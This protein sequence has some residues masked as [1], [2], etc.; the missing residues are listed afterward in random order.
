VPQSAASPLPGKNLFPRGLVVLMG[1]AAIALIVAGI[2][3]AAGLVGPTFLALVIVITIHPLQGWLGRRGVPGWLGSVAALLCAYAVLLVFASA[4]AYSAARLAGLVP[5]Y[6][7]QFSDLLHQSAA[8]LNRVGITQNQINSVLTSFDLNSMIGPL[9]QVLTGALGVVTDLAFIVALLFFLTLDAGSF[10]RRLASAGADRPHLSAALTSFAHGIRQYVV[11]SSIFGLV[12]AVGDVAALYWLSVPLPLL[13]GLLSF[14]TNYIPNI[15]FV[16][17]LAPPALLA[18]LDGGFSRAALV[19]LAY[20]VINVVIQSFIQP[21][22]VG[23]A[24]GLSVT[25]TF[26]SVV[27]WSY[28][29]GSLGALL[30]VPLSLFAK[31]LLVDA[32]PG[33]GWLVP[34]ITTGSQRTQEAKVVEG[35]DPT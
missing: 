26:L 18:L 10:P 25:L 33:S 21:K 27:F 22:F 7:S 4:L 19:V 34:L 8:W 32:D 13:W 12:C 23:E 14:L 1:G 9:Q 11:V 17:G 20:A 5:T 31:A 24:V 29:I 16:I 3:D 6:Q 28:A 30:A 2:R 35:E 15:G